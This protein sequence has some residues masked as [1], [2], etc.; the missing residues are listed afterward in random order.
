[1]KRSKH[2]LEPKRDGFSFTPRVRTGRGRLPAVFLGA[3]VV[4]PSFLCGTGSILLGTAGLSDPKDK[5]GFAGLFVAL[6]VGFLLL[7]V[8]IGLLVRKRWKE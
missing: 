6:G 5:T 4:M 8:M 3:F 2:D 1:M 7:T